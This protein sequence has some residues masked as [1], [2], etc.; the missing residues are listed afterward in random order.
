MGSHNHFTTCV[1]VVY[2]C[3]VYMYLYVGTDTSMYMDEDVRCPALLLS[4]LVLWDSVSSEPEAGS[5]ASKLQ[6][7]ASAYLRAGATDAR[8]KA[9]LE[10]YVGAWYLNSRLAACAASALICRLIDPVF[11]Y[12]IFKRESD[13][14]HYFLCMLYVC[15]QKEQIYLFAIVFCQAPKPQLASLADSLRLNP[16]RCT[17]CVSCESFQT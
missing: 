8:S 9:C 10:F 12:V 5:V 1:T 6:R 11:G 7:S 13:S 4:A 14:L 2:E 15:F 17:L 16:H 3:G